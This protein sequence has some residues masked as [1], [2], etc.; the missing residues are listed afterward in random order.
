MQQL[1]LTVDIGLLET[2]INAGDAVDAI[3]K[4]LEPIKL[5]AYATDSFEGLPKSGAIK[6]RDGDR[7]GEWYIGEKGR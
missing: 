3:Q 7:I 2:G 5:Q 6:D 1:H 4:T